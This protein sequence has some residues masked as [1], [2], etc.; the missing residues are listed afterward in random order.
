MEKNSFIKKIVRGI[1]AIAIVEFIGNGFDY[2]VYPFVTYMYGDKLWAS[3]L[4]LFVAALILN[5]ALVLAYD[6]FKKDWFGFEEIKKIK[7]QAH[8]THAEKT[9][10]QNIILWFEKYGSIPLFLFLSFYDPFMAVLY[11]R[12]NNTF[13]GFT[14]RDYVLLFFCTLFA[15]TIWSLIWSPI[16]LFKK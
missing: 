14:P 16:T 5:Y 6:F 4:V 13:S 11:K 12:K 8:D 9:R 1:S 2:I 15:C 3:F 10:I 7:E